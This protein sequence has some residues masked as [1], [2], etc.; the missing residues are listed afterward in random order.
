MK[1]P[2]RSISLFRLWLPLAL[3]AAVISFVAGIL[4]GVHINQALVAAAFAGV[5]V[6]S[7]FFFRSFGRD[8]TKSEES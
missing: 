6:F 8:G 4:L 5:L 7:G 2:K 3:A 1:I